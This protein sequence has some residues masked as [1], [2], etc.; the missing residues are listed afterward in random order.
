MEIDCSK[1]TVM[2]GSGMFLSICPIF[3]S[4]DIL[5]HRYLSISIQLAIEK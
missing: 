4:L 2:D 1:N 5:L 3:A